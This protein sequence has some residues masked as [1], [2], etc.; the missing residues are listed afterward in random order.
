MFGHIK[1]KR[2]ELKI[3]DYEVYRGVY[4]SLCRELGKRYG[5]IGRMILNYDLA[6]L[7]IFQMSFSD[8]C[9]GFV[10]ARCPFN[11]MKKYNYCK[12]ATKPLIIA[13]DTAV[14]MTYHK[15]KDNIKDGNFKTRF[16]SIFILLFVRRI[17]AKARKKNPD[18]AGIVENTMESQQ[19]IEADN[20]SSVD[21]AAEPTAKA[22]SLLFSYDYNNGD[23]KEISAHFGY[24]LGRWVYLID[25]MEDIEEDIKT[26]S[27]NP[28]INAYC[29]TSDNKEKINIAREKAK[30]DCLQTSVEAIKAYELLEVNRFKD[31]LDNIVFE[32]IEDETLKVYDGRK[33]N[34][35]KSI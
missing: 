14:I 16:I 2:S 1:P 17:Y 13:A 34:E 27:F 5:I 3:K 23:I 32:G 15:V 8:D 35:K 19:R 33:A 26:G 4:C 9:P 30:G 25:A 20:I 31:I 11:P 29:L 24:C 6:F 21:L 12:E 7:A 10:M 22:L 18:I 28:Y